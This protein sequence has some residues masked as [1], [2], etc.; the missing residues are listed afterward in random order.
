MNAFERAWSFLQRPDIEGG[1]RVSDDPDDRGGLTRWGISQRAYP[2]EDIRNMTEARAK[3][4]FRRDYWEGCQCDRLPDAL[5][6]VMADA[7]F[8]QGCG[9]AIRLLQKALNVKVD[10]VMGPVTIGMAVRNG[11]PDHLNEF[12]A[13]RLLRYAGGQPKF[14][15]GWF[16]RVLK[17]KDAIAD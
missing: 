11:D 10:G 7:A 1:A 2:N 16:L 9:T 17:L 13:H 3:E 4:L 6:I 5:A 12:I 15:R 8:N 14:R